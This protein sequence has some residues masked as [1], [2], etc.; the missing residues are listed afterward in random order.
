M[1][2]R[3]IPVARVLILSSWLVPLITAAGIL[4][5]V[6]LRGRLFL[7]AGICLLLSAS[8]ILAA[9]LRMCANLTQ[10]VFDIQNILQ[11]KYKE[12]S[13]M[14]SSLSANVQSMRK[15]DTAAVTREISARLLSGN[16]EIVESLNALLEKL[17]AVQGAIDKKEV[18]GIA[19]EMNTRL[20]SGN[21]EIVENLNTLAER[22]AA[23]REELQQLGNNVL[24]ERLKIVR[25]ELQEIKNSCAQVA[26]DTKDVSSFFSLMEKHLNIKQQ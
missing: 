11:Y 4:I 7:A 15:E 25:E 18:V 17:E 6:F 13:E 20:L 26:C 12:E 21:V 2:N 14:L 3:K 19:M 8:V 10:M 5:A 9:L 1:Y 22:L 24:P 16:A 23:I